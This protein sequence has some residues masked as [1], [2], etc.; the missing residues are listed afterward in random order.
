METGG[1][2]AGDG[3]EDSAGG[4]AVEGGVGVAGEV[5]LADGGVSVG[6]GDRGTADRAG[7]E[8]GA[9]GGAGVGFAVGGGV[10]R[11]RIDGG[12]GAE[13]RGREGLDLVAAIEGCAVEGCGQARASPE[14]SE[15]GLASERR[16]MAGLGPSRSSSEGASACVA[17]L[18]SSEVRSLT[19]PRTTSTWSRRATGKPGASTST[20]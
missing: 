1:P 10:L 17:G 4:C 13:G 8:A 7:G 5:E 18:A 9:R 3:G 19:S 16:D 20:V 2:A 12:A 11:L 14:E 6:V 15:S